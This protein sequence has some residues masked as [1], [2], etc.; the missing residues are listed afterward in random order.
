MRPGMPT[1]SP[2]SESSDAKARPSTTAR[3][4]FEDLDRC[5]RKY[6]EGDKSI[7]IQTVCAASHSRSRTKR[8]LV[9]AER[10]QSMSEAESPASKLRYCQNVSP[11]PARRRP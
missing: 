10:R 11:G 9:P 2:E 8:W 3:S 6:M 5:D 1:R 7:Q 4:A